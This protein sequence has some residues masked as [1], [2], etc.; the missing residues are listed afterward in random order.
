MKD[1][2]ETKA[3]GIDASEVETMSALRIA[4]GVL[5]SPGG[6]FE[7]D[8]PMGLKC[9]LTFPMDAFTVMVGMEKHSGQSRANVIRLLVDAGLEAVLAEM[10]Q[11]Q[12]RQ[13]MKAAEREFGP[14]IRRQ[15]IA[16]VKV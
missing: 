13:I 9:C 15:K 1:N 3:I 4:V 2:E 7:V 16:G 6:A 10:T 11:A 8:G 5:G 12:R 14:G